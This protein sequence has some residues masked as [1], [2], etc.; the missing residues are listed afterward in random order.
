MFHSSF[1]YLVAYFVTAILV[2]LTSLVI[3]RRFIHPLAKIPGP[4]WASITHFDNCY[5][6]LDTPNFAADFF[7]MTGELI[8]RGWV[9][10][11][12]PIL[13]PISNL[14]TMGI[15]KKMNTALYRFLKFR[16]VTHL[17]IAEGQEC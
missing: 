3:H 8:L 9:L 13:G 1:S 15:A 12:L 10:Q 11:A 17:V 14:V 2:W 5:N 16:M 4:F 6:Q 7:N